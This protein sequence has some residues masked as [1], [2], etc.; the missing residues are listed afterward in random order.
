MGE[1]DFRSISCEMMDRFRSNFGS[2]LLVHLS[3]CQQFTV[4]VLWAQLLLHFLANNFET[5]PAVF[6]NFTDD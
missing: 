4:F 3:V 1:N 2:L 6:L 5:P